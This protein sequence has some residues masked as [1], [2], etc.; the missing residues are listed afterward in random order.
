MMG[1]EVFHVLADTTIAASSALALIRLLRRPMRLAVGA[2]IAYWL[3]FLVP[4][5]VAAMLLPAPPVLLFARVDVLPVPVSSAFTAVASR[6]PASGGAL[7]IDL[8]LALWSV[9]TGVMLF[10]MIA[11]QRSFAGTLGA[12]TLDAAGYYRGAVRVP[13]LIG[14]W[15]SR[16]VVPLDFETRYKP[17]ECELVLAH[18]RA[19]AARHDIAVN[20]IA[21]VGLCVLWFNPLM[22]CALAWLRM[23]QELACD[24]LVLLKR[25]DVRRQY[26]NALLKTQLATESAWRLSVGC[27]WQSVHPLKERVAM[28]KRPPPPRG[29]R[30]AGLAVITALTGVV[31]YATWAGQPAIAAGPPILVDFDI[32]ITNP[33]THELREMKT[34]YL[35]NSGE[36]IKDGR[37]GE[38]LLKVGD[39][40][41]GCT[42]YLADASGRSTDWRAQK[43]RGNPIPIAGQILLDCP[44]RRDDGIVQTPTVLTEDGN[45]AIIE[46]KETDGPYRYRL[47]VT[48]STSPE[49]IAAGKLA[50]EKLRAVRPA[51]AP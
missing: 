31:T 13:M 44:I 12:L 2:Q 33:Q 46:I 43:A 48:A 21:S 1:V 9:G 11:R 27:H 16:I 7:L 50:I 30:L 25:G 35:V 15:H 5:M 39:L 40:R 10:S 6:H 3:W 19:H 14:A 20:A 29:R 4:A 42:P 36:T 37:D 32:K 47:E 8:A 34:Q 38:P 28:L 23:D 51:L 22:Y 49:K 24:A 26:A 18:E 45:T 41:F 17:E